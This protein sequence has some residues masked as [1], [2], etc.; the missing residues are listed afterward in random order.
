MRGRGWRP[1]RR[2]WWSAGCGMG[3]VR[4]KGL[5]VGKI[6]PGISASS[7]LSLG[8]LT[9]LL[10]LCA[11]LAVWSYLVMI[12]ARTKERDNC[13]VGEEEDLVLLCAVRVMS[14]GGNAEEFCLELYAFERARE[15]DACEA[16][17]IEVQLLRRPRSRDGAAKHGNRWKKKRRDPHR[18]AYS[19][20]LNK[21]NIHFQG[22]RYPGE[23][24]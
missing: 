19:I 5:Q 12:V 2:D 1:T 6:L 23:G 15:R 4:L 18:F 7:F 16:A 10:D 8:K 22:S 13:L 11:R 14:R 17:W 24:R 3:L 9:D 20:Q 21:R